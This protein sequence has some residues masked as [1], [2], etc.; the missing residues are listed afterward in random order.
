MRPPQ[1]DEWHGILSMSRLTSKILQS[2]MVSSGLTPDLG[3]S[4]TPRLQEF[5]YLPHFSTLHQSLLRCDFVGLRRPCLRQ[6]IRR[7]AV[8]CMSLCA[9]RWKILCGILAPEKQRQSGAARNG[10]PKTLPSRNNLCKHTYGKHTIC[11]SIHMYYVY[12][13]IYIYTYVYIHISRYLNLYIYINRYT[14]I[15]MC[16]CIYTETHMYIYICM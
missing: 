8:G 13:C 14:Y 7:C 5:S 15:Y 16:K 12:V 11:V 4:T 1:P 2:E 10:C 3:T 6:N 9:L